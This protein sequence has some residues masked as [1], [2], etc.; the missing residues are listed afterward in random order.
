MI[1]KFIVLDEVTVKFLSELRNLRLQKGLSIYRVSP[2]VGISH[3]VIS[4]YERGK[5]TPMLENLITLAEYYDYD[6]SES[7]NYRFYYR[8]IKSCDL[9]AELK[10]YGLSTRELSNITGYR[11]TRIQESLKMASTG[12]IL[13]LAAILDVISHER[14][15]YKFRKKLLAETRRSRNGKQ[16]FNSKS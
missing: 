14:E 13:C 8:K 3:H 1:D 15:L 16:R 11:I 2:E 12:T 9:K 7:I 4:R 6:I 5:L 10:R